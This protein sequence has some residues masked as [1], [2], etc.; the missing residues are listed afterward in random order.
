VVTAAA[1][2]APPAAAFPLAIQ[3]TSGEG[4]SRDAADEGESKDGSKKDDKKKAPAATGGGA[5]R[6][7]R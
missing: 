3:A 7:A 5:V 2:N 1:G 4:G 6:F